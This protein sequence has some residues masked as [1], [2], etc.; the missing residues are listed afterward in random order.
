MNRHKKISSMLRRRC[1]ILDGAM[2]TELQ[3]R[4]LPA[5]VC[6]EAWCLDNPREVQAVHE[7]YQ[8]S[9]ADIIYTCTFGANRPKLA[10]YGR[11]D[12]RDM[13]RE[14]ARLARNAVGREALVAGDIGPTGLFVEPFGALPFDE[15]VVIFREQIQGLVEGGVDLLVI[16]T[17]MDIQEARAALLAARETADLFTM[18]TMTFEEGGH[19]LNGTD[20]AAALVTLQSLGAHAV[21]CNCSTGP[22]EMTGFINAM[23][24]IRRVPLVA[25][26]NAGMPRLQEDGS[27]HFTMNADAFARYGKSFVSQGV[28]FMG[29]C[30][31]TTPE[32][33]AALKQ[34]LDGATPILSARTGFSAV[35]SCRKA[36]FFEKHSP[37][38]IIGERINPTG[39]KDL[40]E[41][42]RQ[43][44]T[45]LV[46][47]MGRDQ[48]RQGAHLLDVNVGVP[49]I[50]QCAA[51]ASAVKALSLSSTLPLVIDATDPAV[52]E[53]ALRLYPGR[54]LINSLSGEEDRLEPVL[55]LAGRYGAMFILLPLTG[56][57]VPET[58]NERK[59]IIKNIHNRAKRHGFSKADMVID[60]LVMTVSSNQAAA[61][62]TLKTVEWASRSFGC[63]TV[64]GLSN[65]SFGLPE[66]KWINA[67]FLAMAQS[68]GLTMAIA[69]PAADEFMNMKAAGD[70]LT[71][72]DGDAA[73]YCLRF[74]GGQV[75][76]P[77]RSGESLSLFDKIGRAVMEGS[78][79][80]ILGLLGKALEEGTEPEALLSERLIPAITE[81]GRLY[82]EKYYF[83][84]QLIAAAETM[85]R[86]VA[87]LEP[88][89]RKRKSARSA[90]PGT[91]VMATVEGDIH[92]IG[93]NIVILMLKNQGYTVID[94]GKDVPAGRII[95]EARS[96]RADMVGL[97]A[98]MT[99]TTTRMETT[100]I[101]ARREGLTCPFMV[102]GAVVTSSWAESIGAHYAKD[103]VDAVRLADSL[104]VENIKRENDT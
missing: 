62:E 76:I 1:L 99:T 34:A 50:D 42:L 39:K 55:E 45:D 85:Q 57:G 15:A 37:L 61:E 4:G 49:G 59:D 100:L 74:S 44:R 97:S 19:T 13:N 101:Q 60:G 67:A 103:G 30:C 53:T 81:V 6:P 78:R 69:N 94:L 16:E 43:G 8:K 47:R 84:P 75:Q 28:G 25:K 20:P 93:K 91:I 23:S 12:V 92:D 86:G 7:A 18:V 71:G 5:G 98:L 88:I 80:E 21:G 2:G 36:V 89:I 95:K 27:T 63:A 9:G 104:L 64:L 33:I 77:A 26:P 3:R 54:A 38:V 32:H 90:E 68:R 96:S 48:E 29:G 31:G 65:V 51:M 72:R 82:E 102:G 83:L 46:S 35:S 73:A 66:R 41:E 10:Q 79:D 22:E 52:I 24:G 58:A 11:S 70:V 17:M 14:L 56:S 40:Q 87:F